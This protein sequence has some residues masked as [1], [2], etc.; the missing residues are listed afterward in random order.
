[1]ISSHTEDEQQVI[2]IGAGIA[3]LILAHGLKKVSDLTPMPQWL[4][5]FKARNTICS[6]RER[7]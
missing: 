2:I 4:T 1:M 7:F 5:V 6:L 3:G